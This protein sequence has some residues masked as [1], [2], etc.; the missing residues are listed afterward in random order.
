MST[1]FYISNLRK[2]SRFMWLTHITCD[3]SKKYLISS[4]ATGQ[5]NIIHMRVVKRYRQ[6][7]AERNPGPQ[8]FSFTMLYD[9]SRKKNAIFLTTHAKLKAIKTRLSEF[10]RA[11][12]AKF[13]HSL[14]PSDVYLSYAVWI[15]YATSSCLFLWERIKFIGTTFL[16][17]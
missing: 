4:E 2:K 7:N 8:W 1:P 14:V 3:K 12:C 17:Y 5:V 6:L 13:Q 16:F 15:S 9:W 11:F 10:S